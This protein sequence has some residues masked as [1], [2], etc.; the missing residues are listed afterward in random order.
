MRSQA[1]LRQEG[2]KGRLGG[3]EKGQ[4]VPQEAEGQGEVNR[5]TF[6]VQVHPDG[7]LTLENLSTRERIR[8]RDL[9]AV[10]PQIDLWLTSLEKEREEATPDSA[11]NGGNPDEQQ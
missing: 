6:V 10:G 8:M 3:E 11:I 4:E 2:E 7:P 9:D 1:P 5:F